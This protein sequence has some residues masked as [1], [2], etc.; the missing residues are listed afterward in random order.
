MSNTGTADEIDLHAMAAIDFEAL[1]DLPT[2]W[3]PP[4]NLEWADLANPHLISVR[5][6]WLT[7]QK[8]KGE[9]VNMASELGD[10]ALMELV[11]QIGRS[12]DW[13]EGLHKLLTSA[14]CRIMCA[15]AARCSREDGG[16]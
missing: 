5:F 13:F 4:T 7:L 8:T 2:T 3:H 9:L 12:A 15:Y 14:E 6:A 11:T 1:K 16:R 10:P